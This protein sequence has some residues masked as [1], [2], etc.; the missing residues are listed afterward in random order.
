[1]GGGLNRLAPSRESFIHF[2][3]EDGL[4][5]N[6]VYGILEDNRGNLWISTNKGL[7]HF[8]PGTRRFKNYD[9]SDG[10][11]SDVF[12]YGA[13]FKSKKGEMFFGGINGFN[14]FYPHNIKDNPY[15]PPVVITDF[16]LFNKSVPIGK[17][18]NGRMILE[19]SITETKTV[20]L[21]H[22]DDILSFQFAALNYIFPG[23]NRYAY[24]MEGFEKEWNYVGNRHFATYI[25]LPARKYTFRV[26][27]SNNDDVWNEE[28]VSLKLVI[29]PPLWQT[30]WFLFTLIISVAGLVY[31]FFRLRI[32]AIERQRKNLQH[33]VEERTREL[34]KERQI[35]ESAN[36]AKSQFLARMS[37]EIRTPMNAVIGF[38]DLLLETGLDDEQED[39]ARSIHQGGKAMLVLIGDILDFSKIEAG[40]MTFDPIDFDPEAAAFDICELIAPRVGKKS[41]D[42]LCRIG[43]RVPGLVKSDPD[44]FRQVLLNLMGNAVK[45]TEAGEVELFLDVEEEKK[46]RLKLH[47][48]VRD[49]GIGIAADRLENIFE[50]F[51]Q[52]DG[53]ATRKYEGTGL[54]LAISKQIAHMMKGDVWAESQPGQGSIFHFTAWVEKAPWH[55]GPI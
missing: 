6:I 10:L 29:V 2:T 13:F 52:V 5:N 51:Q 17:R 46:D 18:V 28:G 4:P 12:N 41:I 20:E 44:R 43:D 16:Q 30:Y 21:S 45:F 39:Y 40:K 31:F 47:T 32:R 34:Q 19:K 9:R 50:A 54:G 15:V 53:S 23:K 36:Q 26:K 48:T 22:R 24:M 14:S 38:T 3:E 27:G 25:N 8:N 49:T 55:G 7:S 33:M 1:M 42:I 35:A 37:H 11:Q